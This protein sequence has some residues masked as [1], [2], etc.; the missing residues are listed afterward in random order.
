MNEKI[1]IELFGEE[2]SPASRN[3]FTAKELSEIALNLQKAIRSIAIEA[4]PELDDK[5]KAEIRKISKLE[6]GPI[7]AG[8]AMLSASYAPTYTQPEEMLF[9]QEQILDIRTKSLMEFAQEI[10]N[11][12]SRNA[13]A[14]PYGRKKY[15]KGFGYPIHS[16]NNTNMK[17]T[18]ENGTIVDYTNYS[19]EIYDYLD[20]E[21]KIEDEIRKREKTEAEFE[22]EE[23]SLSG[24]LMEE[25]WGVHTGRID[26]ADGKIP[27]S[28]PKE[29]DIALRNLGKQKVTLGGIAK[30]DEN[31]TIHEFEVEKILEW[32]QSADMFAQPQSIP[33]EVNEIVYENRKAVLSEPLKCVFS[34][35]DNLWIIKNEYLDILAFEEDFVLSWNL[36]HEDFFFCVDHY[37]LADDE[38]LSGD[39]IKLKTKMKKIIKEMI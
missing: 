35:E 30:V 19:E 9:T 8:C 37:L 29:L 15:I 25:D 27:I 22:T 4:F 1:I 6:F 32:N 39:A 20:E 24:K 31:D 16:G 23:M 33:F 21:I 26:T 12:E 17:I 18:I 38:K 3:S 28:F 2:S 10:K 7:E 5:Q 34:F 36:F 14:I 11:A 13:G